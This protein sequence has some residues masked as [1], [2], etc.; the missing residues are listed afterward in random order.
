MKTELT[1]ARL[2]E[3]L[4]YEP[5]TGVFRWLSP[6][7]RCPAGGVAGS[8]MG[9][10]YLY[11]K[12]DGAKYYAHRLAWLYVHGQWPEHQIDHGN[13]VRADNRIANLRD[14]TPKENMAN[15]AARRLSPRW[16]PPGVAE[17]N[18]RFKARITR[19]GKSKRLGS[20]GTAEEAWAA[21]CSAALGCLAE[22]AV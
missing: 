12:I 4:S 21:Y 8:P 19:G 5:E 15:R 10:G 7:G 18:G 3:L 2:R 16:L 22:R 17:I 14:A 6:K 1:Q 13:R 9:E 20:F 11:V